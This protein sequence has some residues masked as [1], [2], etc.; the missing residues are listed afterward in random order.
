MFTRGRYGAGGA[1]C[2]EQHV[3]GGKITQRAPG[4]YS[5]ADGPPITLGSDD[6]KR[7]F[8]A[9]LEISRWLVS[10]CYYF[11]M[12][13]SN[14]S[15]ASYL[16]SHCSAQSF[17]WWTEWRSLVVYPSLYVCF[18]AHHPFLISLRR[19]WDGSRASL[20]L[21]TLYTFSILLVFLPITVGT[22]TKTSSCKKY[23][24]SACSHTKIRTP[25]NVHTL[26]Y[27]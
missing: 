21:T 14:A 10:Y 9:P 3:L 27:Q 20:S 11:Y 23:A 5:V 25:I 4:K 13:A 17:P 24:S 1:I 12:V 19:W 22:G 7:L 16:F 2:R 26:R 18:V 15:A 8:Y 6:L